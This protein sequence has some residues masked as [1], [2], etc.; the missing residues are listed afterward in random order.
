MTIAPTVI[1]G[2]VLEPVS[3]AEV[4]LHARID[5]STEDTLLDLYIT[6]AREYFESAAAYTIHEQTLEATIDLWPYRDYI[7]LPRATPLISIESVTYYDEAGAGTVWSGYLADID[8]IPGRL[9]ISSNVSWP[10]GVTRRHNG[11]RIRYK[12]GIETQSPIVE[13]PAAIKLPV[14]MLVAGMYENRESETFTDKSS[15]AA[16]AMRY[17]VEAFIARIRDRVAPSS[18]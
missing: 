5:G 8:S 11:V 6:A 9:Y 3:A 7:E 4:K 17:G 16:V 15:V 10:S 14:L 13:A 12:A 2:P 18:Y 1:A